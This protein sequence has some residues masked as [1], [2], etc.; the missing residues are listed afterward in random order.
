MKVALGPTSR[1]LFRVKR[2]LMVC[3]PPTLKTCDCGC[4]SGNATPGSTFRAKSP[5][6]A[7]MGLWPEVSAS[8]AWVNGASSSKAAPVMAAFAKCASGDL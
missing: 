8:D 4:V 3:P 6:C 1:Y 2:A 5:S 7:G